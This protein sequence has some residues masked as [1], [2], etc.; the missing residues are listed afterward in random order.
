MQR[1]IAHAPKRI[2]ME[3]Y[4]GKSGFIIIIGEV[5]LHGSNK[6]L[7]HRDSGMGRKWGRR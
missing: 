1:L 2:W 3:R 5:S 4:L 7:S 6:F